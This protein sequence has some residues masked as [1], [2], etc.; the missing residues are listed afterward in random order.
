MYYRLSGRSGHPYVTP[1]FVW[2]GLQPHSQWVASHFVC[3]DD[4]SRWDGGEKSRG[5]V[6]PFD[7][8]IM[9]QNGLCYRP[10]HY[11]PQK[12][13]I[14]ENHVDEALWPLDRYPTQ[15]HHTIDQVAADVRLMNDIA[16]ARRRLRF[17]NG[18]IALNSIKL[19][20]KSDT[21]GETPLMC[22]PYP[23]RDSNKLIEE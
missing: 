23:I 11:W 16:Q 8:Q 7:Y 20:F 17:K 10:Q 1:S 2:C 9:Y 5:L 3:M 4:A 13:A 12:V 6:R 22:E 18:A 21:D 19:T 15:G 14:G